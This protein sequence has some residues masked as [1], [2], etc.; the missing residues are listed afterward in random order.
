MGMSLI[1]RLFIGKVAE[2]AKEEIKERDQG[3]GKKRKTKA[4]KVPRFLPSSFIGECGEKVWMEMKEEGKRIR[5]E[6]QRTRPRDK[7]EKR[8][9][10][11]KG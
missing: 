7:E 9:E 6:R 8:M 5:E 3:K 2:K 1:H 4:K 10:D 11:K